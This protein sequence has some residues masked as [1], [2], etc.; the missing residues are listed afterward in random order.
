MMLALTFVMALWVAAA[1]PPATSSLAATPMPL[2]KSPTT[3]VVVPVS[4]GNEVGCARDGSVR[5]GRWHHYDA[6]GALIDEGDYVAGKKNGVW[7]GYVRGNKEWTASWRNGVEHGV[8]RRYDLGRVVRELRYVSGKQEGTAVWYHPNGRRQSVEHYVAGV[9][10]GRS[11]GYDDTG[12]LRFEASYR[13]G[14]LHGWKRE[15]CPNGKPFF[16]ARFE[17]GELM[18]GGERAPPEGIPCETWMPSP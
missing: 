11:T 5:E 1:P 17:H 15:L 7:T 16:A 4:D 10:E 3:V 8:W 2:C 12:R 9:L 14:V 18:E 13:A 6:I